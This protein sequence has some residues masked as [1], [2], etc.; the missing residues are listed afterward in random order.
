M[1]ILLAGLKIDV[2]VKSLVKMQN[3]SDECDVLGSFKDG[4][5][6]EEID[7]DL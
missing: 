3:E 5:R 1:L 6:K 2:K 4:S 7:G